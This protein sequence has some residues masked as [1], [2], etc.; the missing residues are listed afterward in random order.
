MHKPTKSTG[1]SRLVFLVALIALLVMIAGVAV[2]AWQSAPED[3]SLQDQPSQTKPS[4]DTPLGDQI[5]TSPPG[6]YIPAYISYL[7][8]LE[9]TANIA[10]RQP[11]AVFLQGK[12]YGYGLSYASV[13]V[14]MPLEN[15]QTRLIAYLE[16]T[17]SLGQIGKLA[18]MRLGIGTLFASFG[19]LAVSYGSDDRIDMTEDLLL[20]NTLD[21]SQKSGAAY[22]EGT[23]DVYTNGYLLETALSAGQI[24]TER[25]ETPSLPFVFTEFG[26]T[27]VKGNTQTSS[28]VLP[29][30]S[31]NTTS[32]SYNKDKHSYILY[33]NG[34]AYTDPLVQGD[35]CFDNVFVLFVDTTTYER[36]DATQTV[37]ETASGGTGYYLTEGTSMR[38]TWRTD[39][40]GAMHFLDSAGQP[41]CVNRGTSYM[42]FF[43]SSQSMS[44]HFG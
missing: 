44:V 10:K 25:S 20:K 17:G 3:P 13:T 7:T 15:G 35:V 40:T 19:G 28:V 24:P 23:A 9:T 41:L 18:P 32:F 2:D 4:D 22:T 16:D 1:T 12:N 37:M 34:Q 26:A 27:P 33:K 11:L 30:D 21:L 6:T 39:D 36:A 42:A 43:K 5:Q 14:E 31:A 29:F 38:L 8:G